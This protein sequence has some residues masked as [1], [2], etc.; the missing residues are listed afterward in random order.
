MAPPKWTQVTITRRRAWALLLVGALIG[1]V[2]AWWLTGRGESPE[3]AA[4]EWRPAQLTRE[5]FYFVMTDRFANGDPGNDTGGEP[6]Y[7]P[8]NTGFDPTVPGAYHGGDLKG[9]S[10]RLDYVKGLGTTAIWI[11]PPFVN[12]GGSGKGADLSVGYHGYWISDFTK[13]DPHVGTNA[14]L[15]AFVEAAH[16]KGMKVFLDIVANHTADEISYRDVST[17]TYIDSATRPYRDAKGVDFDPRKVAD[18]PAFPQLSEN[19]SFPRLPTTLGGK[20]PAWL[21]D[22]TMYHNRGDSTF[23]GESSEWGDFF[24]LDD[25][26]TERPEVLD[27]MIAI[28]EKWIDAGVDGF[29]IDTVK[30]VNIEFW[31]RF[32]P[33][34]LDYAKAHGKPDF[35]MFGEVYDVDPAY[36]ST[37]T[38]KGRLQSALDFGFQKAATDWVGGGPGT[39]LKAFFDQDRVYADGDSSAL[40]LATFLGN[41]DM[42]RV[43]FLLNGASADD[44][45]LLQRLRL[46]NALM[47]TSRG[48]PVVYYGDE[49]GLLGTGGDKSARQDLFATRVA[50][51]ATDH[52]LGS[53]GARDRYD[54][55]A[56][57]YRDIAELSALRK[58]YSALADGS[59]AFLAVPE[60]VGVV[61]YSRVDRGSGQELVVLLNNQTTDAS[62][63]IRPLSASVSWT[64]VLGAGAALRPGADG[65]LTTSVPALS[66]FVLLGDVAVDGSKR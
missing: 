34:L 17:N 62:V 3:G 7:G 19:V 13:V 64:P 25:L 36:V 1:S 23:E 14:D 47:F 55:D 60:D 48:N 29:R 4:A 31:Q 56:P 28:Y 54:T 10:S 2:L 50:E 61:A 58:K 11:T 24:G 43:G 63:T 8:E 15:S 45:E 6:D 20:V 44:A 53:Q 5:Q 42:G 59:T 32:S 12:A 66:A 39:N 65:T 57:L 18:A 37:Y 22:V 38:T 35:F 27:G 9:L 30:H 41:H 51:Y 26:F 49:Q 52:Y 40:S 46:A 33:A 16:A 21:D